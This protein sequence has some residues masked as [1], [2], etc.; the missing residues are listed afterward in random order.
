M[1][2]VSTTFFF[3]SRRPHT[4]FSRDWSSDV[5]SSDLN[6]FGIADDMCLAKAD[7]DDD[8]LMFLTVF[9]KRGLQGRGGIVFQAAHK[10]QQFERCF[11]VEFVFRSEERRVG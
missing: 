8:G 6:H 1:A 4:M 3:S 5:C 10:A 9:L 11:E 7:I 2:S